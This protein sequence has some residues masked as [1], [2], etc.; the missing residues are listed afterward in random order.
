MMQETVP[1]ETMSFDEI[2]DFLENFGIMAEAN[3]T[4]FHPLGLEIG[5]NYKDCCVEFKKAKEDEIVFDK[6][7]RLRQSIFKAFAEQKHIKRYKK[8]GFLIQTGDLFRSKDI[9][10]ITKAVPYQMQDKL[11]EELNSFFID[12]FKMCSVYFNADKDKIAEASETYK[13]N[14]FS[15][16]NDKNSDFNNCYNIASCAIIY[17][18][19]NSLYA[20]K[21]RHQNEEEK[22]KEE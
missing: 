1:K 18:L 11:E 22:S 21:E 19:L 13:F 2:C 14:L 15:I 12:I 4:F 7:D 5:L 20:I 6:V 17:Y 10:K 9:K 8:L 16:L 3:R